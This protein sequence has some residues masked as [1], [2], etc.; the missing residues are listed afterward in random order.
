ME[1]ISQSTE[2]QPNEEDIKALQR[3]IA[4]VGI[5]AARETLE[6][7]AAELTEGSPIGESSPMNGGD[8]L[9]DFDT[10]QELEKDFV[11]TSITADEIFRMT[12]SE[13]SSAWVKRNDRKKELESA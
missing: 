1:N 7:V 3:A 10:S 11:P 2:R 4:R 9:D 6:L 8:E 13:R 12:T 5:V